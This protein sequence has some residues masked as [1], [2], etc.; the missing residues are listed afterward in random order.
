MSF[1]LIENGPKGIIKIKNNDRGAV[2]FFVQ[3]VHSLNQQLVVEINKGVFS[4]IALLKG[5]LGGAL[6]EASQW[7]QGTHGY[8]PHSQAMDAFQVH[9]KLTHNAFYE[10]WKTLSANSTF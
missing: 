3:I 4:C 5:E 6:R 7:L 9:R 10:S 1:F 2:G 8:F